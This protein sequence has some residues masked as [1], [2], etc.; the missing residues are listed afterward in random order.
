MKFVF[1]SFSLVRLVLT[2]C[3]FC[4]LEDSVACIYQAGFDRFTVLQSDFLGP[5]TVKAHVSPRAFLALLYSPFF[6]FSPIFLF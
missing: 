6:F 5:L 4:L 1:S 3:D 2:F